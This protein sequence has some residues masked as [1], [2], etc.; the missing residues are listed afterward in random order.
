MD[1]TEDNKVEDDADEVA[2]TSPP[3]QG[4]VISY[5]DIDMTLKTKKGEKHILKHLSGHCQPGRLTA[6][7]GPSGSGK[8]SLLNALAGRTK[9][10]AGMKLTGIIK[11]NGE[12][13]TNWS[14]FRR[15]CA[16][17]EQDDLLFHTL[18]VSETLMLAAE[19]RLPRKL[20]SKEERTR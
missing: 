14:S 5:E 10:I 9:Q 13:V 4:A 18:T 15:L 17:V 7:M 6:L 16:Y 11:V 12:P 2:F 8:T 3:A 20:T 1:K 19:L